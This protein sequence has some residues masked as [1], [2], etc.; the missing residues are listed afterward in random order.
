MTALRLT[1]GRGLSALRPAI[2]RP[3]AATNSY[4]TTFKCTFASQGYG[5]GDG[6][7]IASNPKAQPANTR[8]THSAEHPGPASPEQKEG[9][10]GKG[11]GKS[12]EDASAESGGS[13]SKDAVE[14]GESPTAGRLGGKE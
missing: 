8:A 12:P 4:K 3:F 13:R 11:K 6:D 5:D 9:S 2:H 7:P 14:T 10:K 1:T